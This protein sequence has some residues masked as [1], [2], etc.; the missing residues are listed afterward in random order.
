MGEQRWLLLESLDGAGTGPK[1][2]ER[3]SLS[4]GKGHQIAA[5]TGEISEVNGPLA[6]VLVDARQRSLQEPRERAVTRP[7]EAASKITV[8]PPCEDVAGCT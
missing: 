1:D 8:P 2:G 5:S 6:K 7:W 4:L 3:R